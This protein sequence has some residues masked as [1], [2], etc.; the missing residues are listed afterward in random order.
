MKKNKIKLM[1]LT[2]LMVGTLAIA[3]I[4]AF[5]TDR[6]E[7]SNTFTIGNV[8]QRLLEPTF[9]SSDAENIMPNAVISKDPQV[10]NT[11]ENSQYVLM[12][13]TVPHA[14]VKTSNE[15]GTVNPAQDTALFSYTVNQGWVLVGDK[16]ESA[17]ADGSVNHTFTYMYGTDADTLTVL[18]SNETTPALFDN[19]TFINYALEG[20]G[21][22][23]SLT[24]ADM[25]IKSYGIQT[26][27]MD[28]K[29][30]QEI[31]DMVTNSANT[32]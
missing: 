14:V 12:T 8:K 3:G 22:T 16:T 27:A 17:N 1:I 6:G 18:G 11:G 5:F 9:N 10:K 15:N 4:S 2:T 29:T 28:D 31:I 30:A 13:V 7:I 20:Q 25:T 26:N 21:T 23:N 19:V 32:Y 24:Q